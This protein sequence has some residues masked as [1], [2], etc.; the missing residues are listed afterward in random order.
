MDVLI[1]DDE[2]PA[3]EIIRHYLQDYSEVNILGEASNG[4]EAMKLIGEK[5]PQLIFLDVQMPKL[6]GFEMIE[7]IDNPPEIIFS[8]A[9]DEFAIKAFELNAVDYLLKPYPKQ[10]FDAA[11]QKAVQKL[12]TGAVARTDLQSLMKSVGEKIAD[13]TRIAVKDNKQIHI[14]P[15]HEIMYIEACGDYASLHTEKGVFLKEKTM[16]Y[17]EENLPPQFIRIHRST[18]VNVN[19]VIKI[20]LYEKDSYRVHLKTKEILKA[21]SKGYKTLKESLK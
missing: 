2:S 21:S 1:I 13:L 11:M 9:Y 18:I 6:T 3:R 20:E 12:Q 14:I 7:L 16:K 17:F 15:V 8:T 5:N 4:F 10:R 19:K